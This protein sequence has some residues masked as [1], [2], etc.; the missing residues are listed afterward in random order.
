MALVVPVLLAMLSRRIAIVV[1]CIVLA[2]VAFCVFASPSNA[3]ITL[4]SALYFGSLVVALSGILAR[5]RAATL[6][7]EISTLRS[8]IDRLLSAEETHL[9]REM[10]SFSQGLSF[11]LPNDAA[12]SVV[13]DTGEVMSDNREIGQR[14]TEHQTRK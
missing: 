5:R 12:R 2:A 10:R 8:D 13:P 1:G 14:E 3:T 9:L 7:A 4:A 11:R 6:R